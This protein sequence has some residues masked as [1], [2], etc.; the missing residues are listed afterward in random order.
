[1]SFVLLHHRLTNAVPL[2]R[3]VYLADHIGTPFVLGLLRPNIYL[4]SSL[5]EKEQE[6]I[7]LHE[8]HH[9]LRQDHIVKVLAFIALS[10]HWFNPLVW[11]AFILSGKDMEMSCDEA[12]IRKLGEDIRVDYSASLLSLATGRHTIKVCR[13]LSEKGIR[14]AASKIC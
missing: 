4:P 8:Q 5:S 10:I 12:V 11:I 13:W 6:Y 3:H 9:I 7:L 1:M 14:R 2:Q